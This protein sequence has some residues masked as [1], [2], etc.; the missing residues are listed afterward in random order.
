MSYTASVAQPT[1][2]TSSSTST[3]VGGDG[4]LFA[5]MLLAAAG[6]FFFGKQS[7]QSK[8]LSRQLLQQEPA[9]SGQLSKPEPV[10]S[11]Q[12]EIQRPALSGQLPHRKIE[13]DTTPDNFTY[14]FDK[15]FSL[16]EPE[17]PDNTLLFERVRNHKKGHLFI[18]CETGAGKTSLMLGLMKYLNGYGW[19]FSGS[20]TKLDM[21]GGLEDMTEDDGQTK[22][23]R[24]SSDPKESHTIL[25]LQKRFLW[26][27][28]LLRSR[29]Q[30]Y[31]ECYEKGQE[32]NPAPYIFVLD[33]WLET[34]R[35][36]K[37]YDALKGSR[38]YDE[39]ID[40]VNTFISTSRD[41]K[42]FV[43]VMA[44]D[45]Q[46]QN[47][48]INTGLIKNLGF[49]VIGQHGLLTSV[50]G[51]L[52]SKTAILQ[53]RK[54]ADEIWEEAQKVATE[55]PSTS[56]VYSTIFNHEI[57]VSPYLEGIKREKFFNQGI[58]HEEPP[59]PSELGGT[60]DEIT[61]EERGQ[62]VEM[63]RLGESK[64][65]IILKVW[66]VTKGGS[67]K[68]QVASFRYDEIVKGIS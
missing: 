40:Y 62:V 33:E 66:G 23:I 12:Q 56:I 25:G 60:S 38:I 4:M 63:K 54:I 18:P 61:P 31:Q 45:H 58:G 26:L 14:T 16:Q 48:H 6:A 35:I 67:K 47:A 28:G 46:V 29:Q 53:N 15:P 41:V 1:Q 51:A 57:L 10:L 64:E 37:R 24:L 22:V 39:L 30:Q 5:L 42:I 8:S 59:E 9:L 7:G 49:L 55:N 68:Y 11:G 43:W 34:L 27:M 36:A 21:W 3:N 50:E 17:Q 19:K 44:Q 13:V 32:Y 65:N 2:S 20:T 52:V